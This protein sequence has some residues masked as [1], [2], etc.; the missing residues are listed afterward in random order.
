[1]SMTLRSEVERLVTAHALFG[2]LITAC[3][4]GPGEAAPAAPPA[5][6]GSPGM[7]TAGSSGGSGMG[8]SASPAAPSGFAGIS[9]DPS[10]TPDGNTPDDLT[11]DD[12]TPP[13]MEVLEMLDPAVD[14]E[15]LT[16]IFPTM[17][18]AYDGVHLFQVP[19]HVDGATVELSGW[20][21]IPS[22]SVTFDPI[23]R[24]KAAC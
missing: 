20:Q 18:S 6:A 15:A 22:D 7:D 1:M 5:L 11:P 14:W 10:S 8:G 17:Y 9:G 4:G 21:A 24:W 23:R 12:I 3:G 16:V 13:P 2:M 19:A